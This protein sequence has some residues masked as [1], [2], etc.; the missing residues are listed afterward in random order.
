MK[1]FAVILCGLLLLTGCADNSEEEVKI[2]VEEEKQNSAYTFVAVKRGTVTNE[3]GI[4]CKYAP[5]ESIDCTFTGQGREIAEVLVEKGDFVTKG[6]VLA[7]QNIEEF[8]EKILEE[9]H[10]IE[11][12]E[13]T[14]AQLQEMEQM[15]LDIMERAYEYQDEETRDGETYRMNR[16]KTK[17]RY[18]EQIQD[19]QDDIAVH[20]L[21]LQEY[22]KKVSEGSLTAPATGVVTAS[23][24][25]LVGSISKPS[26]KVVTMISSEALV[27]ESTELEKAEYLEE[28]TVYQVVVPK[29]GKERVVD[30]VRTVD[31]EEPE[32]MFFEVQTP[33][34]QVSVGDA[35]VIWLEL[36]TKENV[37]YLPNEVLCK[38]G[39]KTY[40]YTMGENEIRQIC[41]VKT[42][43]SDRENTEILEGL[44]EGDYVLQE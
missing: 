29:G 9:K 26:E 19:C 33:D 38:S 4:N 10:A 21:R 27:F 14:L 36:E 8:E 17:M 42:G 11:M 7:R 3:I 16:K 15:D 28:G 43:I 5:K 32:K 2:I 35:G 31:E 40:V 34:L 1:K 20:T 24:S 25:D 41:Y 6:Q 12:A 18:E 30:V 37:L 22:Q 23:H 44:E 13:L 39:D